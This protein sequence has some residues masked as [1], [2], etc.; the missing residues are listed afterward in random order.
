MEGLFPNAI[1]VCAPRQIHH[2][3]TTASFE[4][5]VPNAREVR[6]LGQVHTFPL[7]L[8]ELWRGFEHHQH[9]S[10]RVNLIRCFLICV[11][12]IMPWISGGIRETPQ[13]KINKKKKEKRC[14]HHHF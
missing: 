5:A 1:E 9:G 4:C 12:L 11:N 6:A 7:L 8:E 3:E 2:F 13:C 10:L 14:W